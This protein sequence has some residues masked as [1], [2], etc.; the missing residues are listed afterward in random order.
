MH[1]VGSTEH[2]SY[3]KAP[4][5]RAACFDLAKPCSWKHS[6]TVHFGRYV[7]RA[8]QEITAIQTLAQK[9]ECRPE[10]TVINFY[11]GR[12]NGGLTAMGTSLSVPKM[13]IDSLTCAFNSSA[14]ASEQAKNFMASHCPFSASAIFRTC[15]MK[16]TLLPWF[17]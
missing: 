17:S 9:S 11:R 2:N 4:K 16:G 14:C 5:Q 3:L 12:R 8:R 13:R 15:T 7:R 6:S 10:H 1:H